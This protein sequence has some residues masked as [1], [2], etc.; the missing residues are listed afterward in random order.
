MLRYKPLFRLARRDFNGSFYRHQD[1]DRAPPGDGCVL[2]AR[3]GLLLVAVWAAW[4]FLGAGGGHLAGAAVI[5]V[6][7]GG[8][9]GVVDR[10][11]AAREFDKNSLPSRR[12]LPSMMVALEAF[13][14]T[15]PATA[16]ARDV[17]SATSRGIRRMES[18]TSLLK[19]AVLLSTDTPIFIRGYFTHPEGVF[20]APAIT[21]R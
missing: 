8:I 12:P 2:R 18:G 16:S 4:L 5:V 15:M 17:P 13:S 7:T 19:I 14:R 20:P 9:W 10:T 6:L 3:G 11:L 1:D 21:I